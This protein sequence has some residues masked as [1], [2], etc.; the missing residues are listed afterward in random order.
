MCINQYKLI[1]HLG[2][3]AYGEVVLAQDNTSLEYVVRTILSARGVNA[4][5]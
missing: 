3:G 1:S 5:I 4:A 2:Q